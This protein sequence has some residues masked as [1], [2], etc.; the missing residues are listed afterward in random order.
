MGADPAYRKRSMEVGLEQVRRGTSAIISKVTG[1][2]SISVSCPHCWVSITAAAEA[3]NG[4]S[5][6]HVQVHDFYQ[7]YKALPLEYHGSPA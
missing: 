3:E 7:G 6:D 2:K 4:M 1:V 5:N